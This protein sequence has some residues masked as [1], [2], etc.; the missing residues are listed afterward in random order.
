MRD[1]LEI[2]ASGLQILDASVMVAANQKLNPRV[3]TLILQIG[4]WLSYLAGTVFAGA[5]RGAA[6]TPRLV[7]RI[8]RSRWFEFVA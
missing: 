5:A 8:E 2:N 4:W 3:D 6:L 7:M 1:D